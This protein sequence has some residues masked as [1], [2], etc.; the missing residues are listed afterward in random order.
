MYVLVNPVKGMPS[1]ARN[2]QPQVLRLHRAWRGSAQDDNTLVLQHSMKPS[3]SFRTHLRMPLL[4]LPI[5]SF[6]SEKKEKRTMHVYKTRSS[7]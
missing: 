5:P 4:R 2:K 1:A 3:P 7:R 6:P